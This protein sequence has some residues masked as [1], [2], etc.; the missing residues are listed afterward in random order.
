MVYA[1]IQAGGKQYKV[2]EAQELLVEKILGKKE[3]DKIEFKDLLSGKKVKAAVLGEE[4]G[5]KVTIFKYRPRNRYR[6]KTGHR[7]VYTKIKIEKI[8]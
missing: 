8:D 1:V 3:K 5:D 7:Q 2:E 4:K 6:R